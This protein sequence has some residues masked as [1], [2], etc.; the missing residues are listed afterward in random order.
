MEKPNQPEILL[1]SGLDP[2][3]ADVLGKALKRRGWIYE[4]PVEQAE[5]ELPF[6]RLNTRG[7]E[8]YN[9]DADFLIGLRRRMLDRILKE[10]PQRTESRLRVAIN[11]PDFNFSGHWRANTFESMPVKPSMVWFEGDS[12][13]E[14]ECPP[15]R[16]Q[17]HLHD[18]IFVG[19]KE[20]PMEKLKASQID[21][22]F[23]V[24]G[25]LHSTLLGILE[26]LESYG[27]SF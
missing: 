7:F 11:T 10:M 27:K 12:D 26:G 1:L 9:S 6:A 18:L 19:P 24:R 17:E 8:Q 22:S 21:L 20:D 13:K 25:L 3:R 23:S 5:K 15:A 2:K 4:N 16:S 14:R